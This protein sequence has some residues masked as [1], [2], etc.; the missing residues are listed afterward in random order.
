MCWWCRW[1]RVPGASHIAHTGRASFF[2]GSV[3][4]RGIHPAPQ[5]PCSANSPVGRFLT[6]GC[7]RSAARQQATGIDLGGFGETGC[8]VDRITDD[9]VLVAVLGPDVAGD[10]RASRDADSGVEPR[11]VLRQRSKR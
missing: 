8:L 6:C 11:V 1:R 7:N 4:L 5:N 2:G 3:E 10:D 9:G